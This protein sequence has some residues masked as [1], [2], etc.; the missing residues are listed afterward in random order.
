MPNSLQQFARDERG[1][2]A[3]LTA[4]VLPVVAGLVGLS[5]EGG[6]WLYQH[7]NMQSAADS[8]AFSAAV[9]RSNFVVQASA[10]A[11]S[12]GLVNGTNGV[13]VTVNQPPQS[14]THVST[15]GAVEV[16]IN[17]L[18]PRLFSALFSSTPVSITARA[19][20]VNDQSGKGCVLALNG[21]ASGAATL[22]GSTVVN[23]SGCSLFDNS[24]DGTAALT[25][26]GSASLSALAVRVVG[27]ISGQASISTTNGSSTNVAPAADPYANVTNPSSSGPTGGNCCSHGTDTLSPGIYKTGMKLVAGANIT[28][29]PGTYYIQGSGLDVSGGA[30]LT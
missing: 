23:L 16:I 22:Q 27:G 15:P 20:A 17:K 19:V 25:V 14:G 26:G 2:F 7:Q 3:I 9:A 24:A 18:Q 4:V 5:S 8:S 10:V 11:A 29:Q 21:Q 6:L 12:N 13:T 30:T 28:L 1:N